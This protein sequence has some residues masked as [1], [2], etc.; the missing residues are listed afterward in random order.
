MNLRMQLGCALMALAAAG[1]AQAQSGGCNER[2]ATASETVKVPGRPFGV[3]PS[4]DGCWL[5]ASMVGPQAENRGIAV[6]QR[7]GGRVSVTRVVTLASAPTGIV[8]THD[9]KLLIAAT[10][11]GVTFVDVGKMTSGAGD[12]VV[13]AFS[14]GARSGSVYVNVTADDKVLFVSE[15]AASVVTVIDLERARSN[16]YQ[17]S[18]IIGKVPV[19]LAPI[20]LTFSAD[21]K[22]L[23][24]TSELAATDWNWPKACKPEGQDP[25]KSEI[26][27]PEGAVVVVDVAKARTRPAEAVA[28]RVPAECSAVRMAMS[29]DGRRIYVTA[30]NSNAVMAFDTAKLVTDGAHARVGS[31]AV[32]S[33]PVPVA[34]ID[35]G[36]KVLAGNSNRF[37]GASAGE[38]L[39]VLD[40]AKME[41]GGEAMLGSIAVGAFPREMRVSAD[42]HTLF[43][44]NFGSNSIQLI[45]L[46]HLPMKAK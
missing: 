37:G 36:K 24:T 39:T 16:G 46:D 42:G 6:L 21:E 13:G 43:L 11:D 27:Y 10:G 25:A 28:S 1:A 19:G 32:G 31:A 38:T 34:V 14:D 26:T 17:A 9:G 15:E 4:R 45:D 12:A 29:P 20:A 23:Y 33:S 35:G 7:G 18:A 2:A 44:T 8:L 3:V 22:W 5:F 40:A 41:S 30:R